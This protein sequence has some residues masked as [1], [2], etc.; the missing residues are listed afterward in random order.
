MRQQ[1]SSYKFQS[2]HT[3]LGLRIN[4]NQSSFLYAGAISDRQLVLLFLVVERIRGPDSE[5]APWLGVLPQA[6]NTPLFYGKAEMDELK[7]TTL[8]TASR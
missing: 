2:L 4:E 3:L 6:F 7:G 5:W 8:E 1:A